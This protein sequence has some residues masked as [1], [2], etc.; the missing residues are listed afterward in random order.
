MARSQHSLSPRYNER[1]RRTL[2]SAS[3]HCTRS[4]W[5]WAGEQAGPLRLDR[6][7]TLRPGNEQLP[8]GGFGGGTPPSASG[9]RLRGIGRV[10]SVTPPCGAHLPVEFVPRRGACGGVRAHPRGPWRPRRRRPVPWTHTHRRAPIGDGRMACPPWP[11]D[12]R[13]PH[14]AAPASRCWALPVWS[15]CVGGSG[16]SIAGGTA[17]RSR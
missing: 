15:G 3:A 12:C 5:E 14:W 16:G 4:G 13:S 17:P 9:Y 8:H 6:T 10:R 11:V 2:A 7:A 1:R